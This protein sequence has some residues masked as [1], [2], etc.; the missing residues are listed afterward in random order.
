M[1]GRER[2]VICDTKIIYCILFRFLFYLSTTITSAC[3]FSNQ[4]T[5]DPSVIY[6]EFGQQGG[7]GRSYMY[8]FN[9][10]ELYS[11]TAVGSNPGI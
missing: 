8:S 5:E 9:F 2:N 10:A 4:N 7:G 3:V 1:C 6:S 11:K